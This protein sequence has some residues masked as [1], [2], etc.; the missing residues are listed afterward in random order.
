MS[1]LLIAAALYLAIGVGVAGIV[2]AASPSMEEEASG[3]PV[4]V[5]AAVIAIALIWPLL[6]V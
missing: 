4:R 3:R 1:A 6:V 2:A 5:G